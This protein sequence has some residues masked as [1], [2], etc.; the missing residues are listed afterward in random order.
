MLL[1]YI[2]I[3]LAV[4]VALFSFKFYVYQFWLFFATVVGEDITTIPSEVF[5]QQRVRGI[6][7]V[8]D[9]CC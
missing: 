5:I 8:Q 1:F 2:F 4:S 7:K 9:F 3:R 6:S